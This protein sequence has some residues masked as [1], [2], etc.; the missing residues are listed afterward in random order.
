[1]DLLSN[2]RELSY[3]E[4][5]DILFK[6]EIDAKKVRLGEEPKHIKWILLASALTC[7]CWPMAELWCLVR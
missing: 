4:Q 5:Y 6:D 1:M 7:N 3:S 2:F